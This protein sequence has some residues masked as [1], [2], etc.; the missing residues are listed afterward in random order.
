MLSIIDQLVKVYFDEE[1]W[2][3]KR[4]CYDDAVKYHKKMLEQGAI[5]PYTQMG[6]LLGYIEVWRVNFE[7]FGRLICDAP[8]SAFNEDVVNGNIAYVANIWIDKKFRNTSVMKAIKLVFFKRHFNCDY[9]VGEAMRKR[10]Q[11]VKVFT[12]QKLL[13]K[14]YTEGV[15][16]GEVKNNSRE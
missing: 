15:S 5:I 2:H 3:T 4:M 12:R 14:L 8:F 1:W 16:Y 11:P 9:F 10:T 7:Q 13:N 6:V